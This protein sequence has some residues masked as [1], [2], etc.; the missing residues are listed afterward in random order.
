MNKVNPSDK[1]LIERYLA[2]NKSALAF[3]VKK[4]HKVFCD[5]A[6]WILKDKD[7][8]KDVAQESWIII[9]KKINTLK[10]VDSFKSWALRIIYTQSIDAHKRRTREFQDLN[11]IEKNV[12]SESI[13]EVGKTVLKKKLLSAI[14]D[15]SKEKQDV[16]RLFYVEEYTLKE[17]SSFLKIP[18]GTVKSR[19]FKA[20][21]QLK[22][23]IKS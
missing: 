5:K 3:L 12:G 4:W 23:L 14:K 21:E 16:I 22:S 9:I 13:E 19:L 11:K 7:L 18:I 1:Y 10:K 8:A 6:F 20:R 15:L 2:G 17:I